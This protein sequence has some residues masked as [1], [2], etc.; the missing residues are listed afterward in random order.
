VSATATAT[1]R[2]SPRPSPA[3]CPRWGAWCP[4]QRPTQSRAPNPPL[5][6]T[7]DLGRLLGV[8]LVCRAPTPQS[9]PRSAPTASAAASYD[10][11][12]GVASRT[13]SP[14]PRNGHVHV[15]EPVFGLDAP[16]TPRVTLAA[17]LPHVPELNEAWWRPLKTAVGHPDQSLRARLRWIMTAS[18]WRSSSNA[19]AGS[20][21]GSPPDSASPRCRP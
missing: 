8:L 2:C 18:P 5:G 14:C 9:A 11:L 21:R 3:T 17:T 13:C 15:L 4:R 10:V 19:R 7:Y 6:T 1:V 16:P 20:C 12:D